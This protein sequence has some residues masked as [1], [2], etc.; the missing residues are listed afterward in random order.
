[1]LAAH[2]ETVRSFD[3]RSEIFVASNDLLLGG[4]GFSDFL[5]DSLPLR[6]LLGLCRLLLGRIFGRHLLLLLCCFVFLLPFQHL[7]RFLCL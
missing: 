2:T 7:Q 1:M 4:F 6:R 5:G 3:L